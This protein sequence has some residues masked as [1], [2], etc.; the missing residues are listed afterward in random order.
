MSDAVIEGFQSLLTPQFRWNWSKYL[1]KRH[2]SI[3]ELHKVLLQLYTIFFNTMKINNK[4]VKFHSTFCPLVIMIWMLVL[5]SPVAIVLQIFC[6]SSC[7]MICSK[8]IYFLIQFLE[9]FNLN[10]SLLPTLFFCCY[11]FISS[12]FFSPLPSAS[13]HTQENNQDLWSTTVGGSLHSQDLNNSS[14]CHFCISRACF[15]PSMR[16][17]REFGWK[18][19]ADS[20]QRPFD[21]PNTSRVKQYSYALRR[22]I[23][24]KI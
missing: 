22:K 20:F 18:L 14:Q 7:E 5:I 11:H 12:I 13:K 19:N 16:L 4:K 8:L 3:F 24:L 6:L 21:K 2:S 9:K 10:L 23:V 15:P 1:Q 17:K